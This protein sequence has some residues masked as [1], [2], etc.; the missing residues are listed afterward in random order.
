MIYSDSSSSIHAIMKMA[1]GTEEVSDK[2]FFAA[3]H[4]L[5]L[6]KLKDADGV[7]D[8]RKYFEK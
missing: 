4:M 8:V 3:V 6:D 7:F 5:A 1:G 2:D